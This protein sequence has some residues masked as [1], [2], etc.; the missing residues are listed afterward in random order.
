MKKAM[1]LVAGLVL[2]GFC[3]SCKGQPEVQTTN[4]RQMKEA[5]KTATDSASDSAK[6]A[7]VEASATTKQ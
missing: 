3:V 5:A 6:K 7:A 4:D 1:M 2:A